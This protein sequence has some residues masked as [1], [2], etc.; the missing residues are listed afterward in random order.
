MFHYS[1][2][3]LFVGTIGCHKIREQ[4]VCFM[5][6]VVVMRQERETSSKIWRKGWIVVGVWGLESEEVVVW[7]ELNGS[8]QFGA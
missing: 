1:L 6:D 3:Q 8:P 7:R 4:L 2:L 5:L